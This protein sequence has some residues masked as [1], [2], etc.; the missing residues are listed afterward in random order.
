MSLPPPPRTGGPAGPW[1]AC[2][3]HG[4]P[5]RAV[6]GASPGRICGTAEGA[7]GAEAAPARAHQILEAPWLFRRHLR[8][9]C[10]LR[11]RLRRPPFLAS[12][13]HFA[14]S[15]PE[16]AQST[17]G[18]VVPPPLPWGVKGFVVRRKEPIGAGGAGLQGPRAA[19]ITCRSG[20]YGRC[21]GR[22]APGGPRCDGGRAAVRYGPSRLPE[23]RRRLL[24]PGSFTAQPSGQRV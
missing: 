2:G 21:C 6:R 12:C 9:R 15:P 16:A 7:A 3:L 13:R 23:G 8:L 4:L 10:R 14:P 5:H 19:A 17:L 11:L 18:A 24:R 20:R 22:P 1:A